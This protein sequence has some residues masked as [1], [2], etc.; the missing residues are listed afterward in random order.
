MYPVRDIWMFRSI[1]QEAISGR[2]L[3]SVSDYLPAS[4]PV[5]RN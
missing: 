5:G 3:V 2:I 4:N 1:I